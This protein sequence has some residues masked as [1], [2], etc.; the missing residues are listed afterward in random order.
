MNSDKVLVALKKAKDK[1]G[2]CLVIQDEYDKIKTEL[3]RFIK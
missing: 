3:T 1:L 2:L